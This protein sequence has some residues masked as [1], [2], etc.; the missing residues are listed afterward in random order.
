MFKV[1]QTFRAKTIETTWDKHVP[2]DWIAQFADQIYKNH[3]QTLDR[4]EERGGL[5]WEE[6]WH[7]MKGQRW[8]APKPTIVDM[9]REVMASIDHWK[10]RNHDWFY[11]CPKHKMMGFAKGGI[12][13][14]CREET[15]VPD[16]PGARVSKAH[17]EA[18]NPAKPIS[19][20]GEMRQQCALM[21]MEIPIQV[22]TKNPSLKPFLSQLRVVAVYPDTTDRDGKWSRTFKI[23]VELE[24][25]RT[26]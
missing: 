19:T 26:R 21:P 24:P 2:W 12:C 22:V 20:V 15:T 18:E 25:E 3:G 14:A 10:E 4:L 13:P 7:A 5:G 1:L 8:G 16:S 6:I 17:D 23:E 11:S 9:H